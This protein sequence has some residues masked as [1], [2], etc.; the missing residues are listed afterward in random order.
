[1]DVSMRRTAILQL[2]LRSV[3]EWK[4]RSSKWMLAKERLKLGAGA[5]AAAAMEVAAL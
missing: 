3:R 2:S 5:M 4:V 1:M